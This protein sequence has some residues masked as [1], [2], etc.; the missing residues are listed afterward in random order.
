M[1]TP[2]NKRETITADTVAQEQVETSIRKSNNISLKKYPKPD[3]YSHLMN[4]G[5]KF[6]DDSFN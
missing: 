1:A 3:T 2:N 4:S 6:I 5:V